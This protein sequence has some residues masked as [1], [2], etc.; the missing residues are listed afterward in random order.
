MSPL[1]YLAVLGF[2][3][4]NGGHLI[5]QVDCVSVLSVKCTILLQQERE[6]LHADH[7]PPGS[8]RQAMGE[9]SL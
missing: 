2:S 6:Q 4:A 3:V 7:H 1:G 9:R 8:P 5:C